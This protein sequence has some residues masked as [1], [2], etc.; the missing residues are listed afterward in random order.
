M[1][2]GSDIQF[3]MEKIDSREKHLNND[4]APIIA[5]YKDVSTDHGQ[6]RSAIKEMEDEKMA[7]EQNFE[8]ISHEFENVKIQMEQRGNAMAD[9][10][11]LINIKRAIAK[12]KEEIVEME[13][14]ISVMRHSVD[15]DI[16]KQNAI[17]AEIE[18]TASTAVF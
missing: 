3:A 11:P 14:E 10:S 9:G 8:K 15:Q 4:L 5:Q 7:L 16:L 2:L 18:P 12:I 13:L 6:L 1:R 17:Y